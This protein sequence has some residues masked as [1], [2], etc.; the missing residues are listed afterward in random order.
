MPGK[1]VVWSLLIIVMVATIACANTFAYF[2]DTITSTGNTITTGT[3]YLS[4]DPTTSLM[5]ITGVSPG[6]SGTLYQT[7]SNSGTLPG[8]LKIDFGTITESMAEGTP[9]TPAGK[10]TLLHSV[11]V[12]IKLVKASDGT[13][14]KQ[15]TGSSSNLVPIISCSGLSVSNISVDPNTSY[16]LVIYYEIPEKTDSGIQ[17][18]KLT[19]DVTYTLSQ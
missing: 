18:K 9:S 15:L 8:N 14:V 10:D 5:T 6:S 7:V 2:Q 17:G 11:R 3:L 16:K 4:L 13:L 19:F 12:N 1:R